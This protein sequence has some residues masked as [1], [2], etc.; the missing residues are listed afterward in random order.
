MIT[1]AIYFD[2]IF[3]IF[4]LHPYVQNLKVNNTYDNK[5]NHK[6]SLAIRE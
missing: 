5:Y 1:I 6:S 3:S 4:P 2:D